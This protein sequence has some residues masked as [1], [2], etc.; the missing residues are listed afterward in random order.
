MDHDGLSAT[1]CQKQGE[2]IES[3]RSKIAARRVIVE[4]I[5]MTLLLLLFLGAGPVPRATPHLEPG[6]KRNDEYSREHVGHPA[7]GDYQYGD[8]EDA[9]PEARKV[10]FLIVEGTGVIMCL[11]CLIQSLA[12]VI[13]QSVEKTDVSPLRVL[14]VLLC[15]IF[16]WLLI[17]AVVATLR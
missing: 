14:L 6:T 13:F 15:T 9:S 5:G 8:S 7:P 16:L 11:M 4:S 1:Y 3:L 12:V 10:F 17:R 2:R